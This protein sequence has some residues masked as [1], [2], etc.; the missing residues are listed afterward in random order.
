MFHVKHFQPDSCHWPMQKPEKISRKISSDFHHAG[1]SLQA[2]HR[3]AQVIRGFVVALPN[4]RGAGPQSRRAPR[5]KR[6]RRAYHCPWNNSIVSFWDGVLIS[7]TLA[8]IAVAATAAASLLNPQTHRGILTCDFG[9]SPFLILSWVC[10]DGTG[11]TSPLAVQNPRRFR[12]AG[13][14]HSTKLQRA[15]RRVA[16]ALPARCAADRANLS[17]GATADVARRTIH[18]CKVDCKKGRHFSAASSSQR[19]DHLDRRG[20][21]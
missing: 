8:D 18:F 12:C 13:S 17:V 3:H 15:F 4:L 7:R 20:P 16:H 2:N 11:T 14:R 5:P 1:Q 9:S 21:M 6:W 19:A 10:A